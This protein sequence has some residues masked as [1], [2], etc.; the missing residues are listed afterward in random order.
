M[1]S[2][3]RNRGIELLSWWVI[4]TV[5]ELLLVSAVDRAELILAVALGLCGAVVA[6]LARAAQPTSW[7]LPRWGVRALLRLPAA[8][9]RDAVAVLHAA[10]RGRTGTWRRLEITGGAGDDSAAR[11]ARAAAA[12]I[13][14]VSAATVIV[15]VDPRSG[16]ALVH[17]LG[18]SP[19]SRLEQ[20]VTQ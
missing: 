2:R 9:V 4:L 8:V 12:L 20:A 19:G 6:V 13:V 5:L 7:R 15:G 3:W 1:T 14:S 10:A 17:D 16:A 11:G 18:G